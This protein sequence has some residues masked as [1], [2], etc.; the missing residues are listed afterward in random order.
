MTGP[1]ILALDYGT[2]RVGVALSDEL[3]WTA[4]PL[5]TFER[6]TLDRD[7]AH[8]ASLV[9][10][11]DVGLVLLGLP[12]QLDGREGPA[13]EAMREFVAGLENGLTVPLVRW[14]ERMTTKAAEDLLIAADVSRKKRKGAIDRVAAAILL[15]S[16][17]ASLD[18]PEA[19]PGGGLEEGTLDTPHEVAESPRMS[20]DRRTR[21][22]DRRV[23]DDQMG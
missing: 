7:I 2:K 16:Y 12:L 9:E 14:D 13:V 1:R 19:E 22:R 5:E 11:H 6:R 23:S 20:P 8:I 10:L 18:N 21:G 17:L 4:Q 15:Q 3:R